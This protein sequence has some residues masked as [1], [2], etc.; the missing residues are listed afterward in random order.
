M[1]TSSQKTERFELRRTGLPRNKIEIPI[2]KA[3]I[4]ECRMD[5]TTI[6][7]SNVLF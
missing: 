5:N 1:E 4:T 6:E 7:K 2:N 3:M